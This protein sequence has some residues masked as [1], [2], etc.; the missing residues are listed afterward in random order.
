VTRLA[1]GAVLLFAAALPA[2]AA[3]PQVGEEA[4]E[5]NTVKWVAN[6]PR[7]VS[8]RA[9]R[10]EVVFVE[11]WGVKCPPCL[12]LIPHVQQMQDELGPKGLHIFA[13]EAQG[14]S[15]KEITD[16]LAQR[17]GKTYPVSAG[18]ADN[19]RTNGGIP[20]G[21]LIGVDGKVVW[22][23]NP[24]DGAFEGALRAEMAKVRFPALTRTDLDKSL[25]K[26]VE[27]YGKHEVGAARKEAQKVLEGAK[28]SD[29]A[30]ADAQFLVDH[31]TSLASGQAAL[32]SSYEA[33]SRWADA[34]EVHGWLAAQFKKEPEGEAAQGRL[35]AMKGD[36][37]IKKELES[38]KKLAQ[39]L[40]QVQAAPAADK[41]VA[42]QRFVADAKNDGTR[43]KRDAETA[44]SR[45]QG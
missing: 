28:S 31:F 30:K 13:F 44:L 1:L 16:M 21:W 11:K 34:Q 43:A 42:L 17:G 25:A 26:A 3:S 9:L 41:K 37:A 39:L 6:Q 23:G 12:A 19:Y 45:L 36:A 10:G 22:E 5:F 27:K 7:V 4:P 18:G 29:T 15:P 40:A 24:G 14:H 20:H 2:L 35:D 38:S 8:L 33:E 32:A